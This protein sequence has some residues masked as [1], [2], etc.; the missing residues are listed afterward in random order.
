MLA[1]N[2]PEERLTTDP[3]VHLL[4]DGVRI[5]AYLVEDG[6]SS[7]RIPAGTQHLKL[8]SR[9]GKP[10][11]LGFSTDSRELGFS[12]TLLTAHAVDNAY[13]VTIQPCHASLSQGFHPS[14]GNSH[15]W[16]T[17]NAVLPNL[18][19]GS[20]REEVLLSIKG[21]AL[22]RYALIDADLIKDPT[23]ETDTIKKKMRL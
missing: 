13:C 22:P 3:D 16:T 2:I 21:K 5:D 23:P 17:G 1:T 12:V 7:F 20:G 18:L 19:L 15:R 6:T 11:D 4:A 8:K 10:S 14:E 9:S